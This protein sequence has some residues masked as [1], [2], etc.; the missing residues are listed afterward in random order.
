M[1]LDYGWG[2]D[3][4]C[5]WRLTG[6]KLEMMRSVLADI[7]GG[8][9]FGGWGLA[10]AEREPVSGKPQVARMGEEGVGTGAPAR[11]REVPSKAVHGLLQWDFIT[12]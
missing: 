10:I 2:R 11:G 3:T 9:P 12:A 5:S 6:E 7:D 4:N 8:D 1:S